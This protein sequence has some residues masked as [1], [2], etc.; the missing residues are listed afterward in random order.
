MRCGSGLSSLWSPTPRWGRRDGAGG[1]GMTSPRLNR[2]GLQRLADLRVAE[3]RLLL[4]NGH[5][6]GAYYLAGYAVECALKA[7][8]AKQVR[9]Y[10][11]P[12]RKLTSESYTHNLRSLLGTAGLVS[13]LGQDN[14]IYPGLGANWEEV[15]KWGVESRYKTDVSRLSARGF[16][17]RLRTAPMVSCRGL[18]R[19][20]EGI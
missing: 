16:T 5:Y 18:R 3:A 7:C 20:G 2:D 9:E 15:M 11:F 14:A 13:A 12:D 10:D 1:A 8:I 17:W 4:D 19:I 6:S